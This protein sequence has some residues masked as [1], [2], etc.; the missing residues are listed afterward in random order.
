MGIAFDPNRRALSRWD[1]QLQ[2]VRRDAERLAAR[3]DLT[4]VRDDAGPAVEVAVPWG[5]VAVV[6]GAAGVAAAVLVVL[7]AL[8]VAGVV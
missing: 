6:G 3:P 8:F 1:L 5:L 7:V 4:G 2:A